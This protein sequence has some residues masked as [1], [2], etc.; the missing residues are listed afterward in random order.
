M[1][2]LAEHLILDNMF[3]ASTLPTCF[4]SDLTDYEAFHSKF[5]NLTVNF[6]AF[7]QIKTGNRSKSVLKLC[8][9][10]NFTLNKHRHLIQEST[11]YLAT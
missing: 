8:E 6:K 1:T 5:S 3:P 11:E 10:L 7:I 9:Y 4:P 2:A